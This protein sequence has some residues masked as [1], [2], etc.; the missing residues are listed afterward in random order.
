MAYTYESVENAP[1]F[2]YRSVGTSSEISI[3]MMLWSSGCPLNFGK[4]E[5]DFP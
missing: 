2:E 4:L 3:I 5:L 1:S